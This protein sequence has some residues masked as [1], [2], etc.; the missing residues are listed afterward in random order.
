MDD[1]ATDAVASILPPLLQ[2]LDALQ[3]LARHLHP[4]EFGDVLDAIG[5][6]DA[7]LRSVAPRL[8]ELPDSLASVRTRLQ[9]AA[10]AALSAFDSLRAAVQQEGDVR[11][12]MG[13]FRN[14]IVA[15]EALYPLSP[16]SRHVSRFFLN[17]GARDDPDIL[18]RVQTAPVS[19]KTGLVQFGETASPRGSYALYVPETYTPDRAWPL[20]VAL[21][22]GSGNGRLFL[23]SWLRDARSHGAILLAP[24]AR[25]ST[26]ALMGD[27]VD[28]PNLM[29]TL[30]Q[31]R[32]LWNID[33]TRM[34]LTGMSD[35]G[36]FSYVSGLAD[37]SPFTHLAP[38][39]G[40]FHPML[41]QMA[42]RVRL[43]DLPVF[44]T[45]GV[46]DWM[47]PVEAAR[48]AQRAFAGLGARVT[49]REIEDLSHTYPFEINTE[50]LH[51][52]DATAD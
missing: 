2:A 14:S 17:A 34:L 27:D 12:V 25:G 11:S 47:F 31:I 50:I 28:T 13:A 51:W 38:V 39:A 3:F 32:S 46:L 44:I 7:G 6:P 20:V 52:V 35:G 9:T 23:W 37:A 15:Q 26:W 22:G 1:N 42:D 8:G 24:T 5:M 21:H 29:Q 10:D 48:F 30:T 19:C 36:T 18:A 49:Y 4:P 45:H 33:A 43:R 40:T 16:A 41:V